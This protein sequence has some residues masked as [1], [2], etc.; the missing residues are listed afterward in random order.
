MKILVEGNSGT[1]KKPVKTYKAV[2][3]KQL[4]DPLLVKN[5]KKERKNFKIVNEGVEKLYYFNGNNYI[6]SSKVVK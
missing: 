5:L 1:K 6:I 4:E 2:S 3:K